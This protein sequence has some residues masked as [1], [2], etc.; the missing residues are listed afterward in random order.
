MAGSEQQDD[1]GD[2]T[3]ED[4]HRAGRG[5]IGGERLPA[6]RVRRRIGTNS[7][8]EPSGAATIPARSKV[9]TMPFFPCRLCL[10]GG[11][12]GSCRVP[13]RSGAV[14]GQAAMSPESGHSGGP[15]PGWVPVMRFNVLA[16]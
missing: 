7:P 12:A 15:L 8:A 14:L 9:A 3:T 1:R 16:R 10:A 11:V 6:A 13:V 4:G 2:R 5:G